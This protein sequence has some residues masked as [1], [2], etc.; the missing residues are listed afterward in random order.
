MSKESKGAK[1]LEIQLEKDI[2]QGVYANLAIVNHTDAEVTMDFVYVQPQELRGTVRS[3]VILS[4]RHA[5]RLLY[6]LKENLE[7]YEKAFGEISIDVAQN[8]PEIHP[9]H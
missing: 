7:R 8:A 2:A 1:A 5:K 9:Y 3:R 4:P 6:A